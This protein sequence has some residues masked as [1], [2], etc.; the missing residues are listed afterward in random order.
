ML[1]L[2]HW[3]WLAASRGLLLRTCKLTPLAHSSAHAY[4]LDPDTLALKGADTPIDPAA[5]VSV[6]NAALLVKSYIAD[7][8]SSVLSTVEV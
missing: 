6:W 4:G 5:K 1:T 3:K 7:D 2:S 8:L